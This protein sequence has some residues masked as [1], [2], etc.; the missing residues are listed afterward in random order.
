VRTHA[1]AA[2]LT[3]SLETLKTVTAKKDWAMFRPVVHYLD[4]RL[5]MMPAMPP[6]ETFGYHAREYRTAA[7]LLCQAG[8][9]VSRFVQRN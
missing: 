2:V 6:G 9:L 7:N 1:I 3:N 8:S 5:R 4:W